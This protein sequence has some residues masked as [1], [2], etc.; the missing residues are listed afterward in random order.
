M[1]DMRDRIG[2]ALGG[3]FYGI[4]TG[5][6]HGLALG[7]VGMAAGMISLGTLEAVSEAVIGSSEPA[8]HAFADTV[9]GAEYGSDAYECQ[10][11]W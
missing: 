6:W 3:A 1:P 11:L 4:W 2:G 10:D 8:L 7:L 5:F 9:D